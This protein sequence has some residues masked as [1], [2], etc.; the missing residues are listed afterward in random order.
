MKERQLQP[1]KVPPKF[2][3]DVEREIL[4]FLFEALFEPII[5]VMKMTKE[6]F[7][8]ASSSVIEDAIRSG[9][10]QFS[11]GIFKGSFN[12]SITSEFRKLGM[13]FDKRIKGYR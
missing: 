11:Q 3:E 13:K 9:K 6:T 1:I 4:D 5:E 2:D 10:I 8:N 7:F 12:A